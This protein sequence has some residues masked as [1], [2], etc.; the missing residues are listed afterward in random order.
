M[1]AGY[2]T[3][4]DINLYIMQGKGVID[5]KVSVVNYKGAPQLLTDILGNHID[6][7]VTG[8]TAAMVQ[9]AQ[10][11]NIRLLG[12]STEQTLDLD[13]ISVPSISKTLNVPQ[14]KSGFFLTA[15][16]NA[17]PKFVSDLENDVR[18]ILA[19]PQVR[20]R[21]KKIYVLGDPIMGHDA[22]QAF[23]NSARQTASN[24]TSKIA[25]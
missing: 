20:E 5:P 13:G 7:G 1:V 16:A 17:D 8:I 24:Y 15:K 22:V 3:A 10:A 2:A 21:M 9:A 25:R 11:G 6:A 4:H 23:V 14:M 18:T 12:N 19:R